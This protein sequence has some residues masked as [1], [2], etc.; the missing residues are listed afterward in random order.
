MSK[1]TVDFKEPKEVTV[2]KIM[3]HYDSMKKTRAQLQHSLAGGA[4]IADASFIVVIDKVCINP[5]FEK[6]KIKGCSIGMPDKV[7]RFT[8]PSAEYYASITH[9]GNPTSVAVVMH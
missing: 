3:E 6:G 7:A 4:T 1:D 2:A 5:I 8:K 9:N